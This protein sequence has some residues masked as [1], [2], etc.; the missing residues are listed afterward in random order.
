VFLNDNF[1]RTELL[2]FFAQVRSRH[3]D[4]F[5]LLVVLFEALVREDYAF[6]GETQSK[7]DLLTVMTRI[8]SNRIEPMMRNVWYCSFSCDKCNFIWCCIG[9]GNNH[10]MPKRERASKFFFCCIHIH[11]KWI[12]IEI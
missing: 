7:V 2:L 11:S 9:I 5:I 4:S 6:V 8:E 10:D 3:S 12:Q 1:E